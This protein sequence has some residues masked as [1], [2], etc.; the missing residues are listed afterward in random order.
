MITILIL[1][2]VPGSAASGGDCA[3][4]AA[5]DPAREIEAAVFS[6]FEL[7]DDS[8]R[9]RIAAQ[10]IAEFRRA[11][12]GLPEDKVAE[13][14]VQVRAEI[15]VTGA[16]V[17]KTGWECPASKTW[18]VWYLSKAL[19]DYASFKSEHDKQIQEL[20]WLGG[21]YLADVITAAG[22]VR[23]V[24]AEVQKR[25]E[26]QFSL[27]GRFL[28]DEVRPFIRCQDERI[29]IA[30]AAWLE[31][32]TEAALGSLIRRHWGIKGLF[33]PLTEPLSDD[34]MARVVSAV[35]QE[36]AVK[37][38]ECQVGRLTDDVEK[39]MD[40]LDEATGG[41]FR[42]IL[43][44]TLYD[45]VSE[46]GTPSAIREVI[47]RLVRQRQ[48]LEAKAENHV[49]VED[50]LYFEARKIVGMNNPPG[51]NVGVSRK[52]NV[53]DPTKLPIRNVTSTKPTTNRR[54]VPRQTTPPS[55]SDPWPLLLVVALGA[56]CLGSVLTMLVN[57]LRKR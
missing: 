21:Q 11:A 41:V 26:G 15:R 55:T 5:P 17:S 34:Q 19:P 30:L 47:D 35:R 6:S 56:L 48:E 14:L 51:D 31:H 12:E 33:E 57:R 7:A 54:D 49:S 38:R 32:E 8:T 2:L 10:L 20:S 45:S 39:N 44:W 27:L 52:P 28:K 46:V 9:A 29:E 13:F 40:I 23:P 1:L 36:L 22:A 42:R 25:L 3:Q 37:A 24:S 16:T 50:T 4:D 53:V 18:D 43:S